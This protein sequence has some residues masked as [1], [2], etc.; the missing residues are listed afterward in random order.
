MADFEMY[1]PLEMTVEFDRQTDRQTD[2]HT[3]FDTVQINCMHLINLHFSYVM[4]FKS[5][6][7]AEDIVINVNQ[8]LK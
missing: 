8:N 2:T 5:F 1:G 7:V 4:I 6:D 3:P